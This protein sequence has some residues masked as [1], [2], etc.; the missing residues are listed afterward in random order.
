MR[1]HL[2]RVTAFGAFGR[3]A[4]V[5]F[6]ELA[7]SGLFLLHGETGAGKTTLLD[8]IGFALYGRVPG[9]RNKTKRLR[10]DHASAAD[11]TEVTFET[12]IGRR[13]LRIT[14][15]PQQVRPKVQGTGTTSEPAR[16]LLEEESGGRWHTVS[17]RAKEA[18]DEI[19]DAMGMS[20]DQFFQVVLLPQGQ[21]AQFLHADADERR[22]LLQRLFRTGRFRAVE[23]WLA[24]RRK[25]TRDQVREAEQALTTLAARIAQVAGVPG[26]GEE[27]IAQPAAEPAEEPAEEPAGPASALPGAQPGPGEDGAAGPASPG[28]TTA[29]A[30]ELAVVAESSHAANARTA[31]VARS[32]LDAART[33]EARARELAGR[34]G[35]RAALLARRD[36]LQ[37][38]EPQRTA[39]RRELDA[40]GRAA[41]ITKV[42]DDAERATVHLATACEAESAA[43]AAAAA[44]GLPGTAV[45]ADFRAAERERRQHAGHLGA[46]REEA[47]RAETEDATAAAARQRAVDRAAE[48][49]AAERALAELRSRQ[50]DLIARRDAARL[51]AERLPLVRADADR[52]RTAAADA[53][54]LADDCAGVRDLREQRESARGYANDLR[55]I[56]QRIREE[57]FDGMIAELVARLTDD[58]PCP[59]CGSLDHPEP[60]EIQ[61]RR[62]THHEEEQAYAEAEA[63]KDAVNKLDSE[64]AIVGARVGDL[65]GRLMAA[66]V[67]DPVL[68]EDAALAEALAVAG[69]SATLPSAAVSSATLPGAGVPAAPSAGLL[70][71][72]GFGR[73][74]SADTVARLNDLAATLA[75]AGAAV[76]E[77]E[78][79]RLDTEAGRLSRH[80]SDLTGLG[81]ALM[82]QERRRSTLAEQR[83]GALTEAAQADV[84]AAGHRASL[85]SQLD[86]APD[87]ETALAATGALADALAAAAS[88]AEATVAAAAAAEQAGAEAVRAAAGAR[89]AD[90]AA[91]RSAW[92]APEWRAAQQE[93]IR[94]E[95]TEAA[96]VGTQLAGPDLD[97]PL[98]PPA[99]LAGAQESVRRAAERHDEAVT[100]LGR[101]SD[102]SATL[103]GLVPRFTAELGALQPLRE[104]AEEARR[105]ADLA[106]G[107]GANTL[108]MTLSSFVLAARL[109]EVA[110]AASQRLLT[111]TA[112]RYSLAHTD[113]RR[114]GGRAG[115]G[116]LA[117]DTW[118]GQE[119]DTS[120]LSGGET[121]L[122]SL[123]LALGLADVVTAEAAGVTIEALF[124]D[125]GFGSLDEDTLEEVMNVLDGLREGGRM[126][127]IVSHVSELRQ[128]IPAQVHVR[129]GRA[130]STV[131][132]VPP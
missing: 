102:R 110:E 107:L 123:A 26:P 18:D 116:L 118:T 50:E 67:T 95:E 131:E 22:K 68:R 49:E 51:A 57:R 99:D 104:R 92:Q 70:A 117:C 12:T 103:A 54:Q 53:A 122:A 34:Q 48:I 126:V 109:E 121:F 17:T 89:F 71:A 113:A 30:H 35:R 45:A 39:V 20:A 63:A 91:A 31:Q 2:L 98:E 56:A 105:L 62:V 37:A 128:R 69:T 82:E 24:E 16:I 124:V 33:A 85:R 44:A 61:A 8:A 74:P 40:A 42:L 64:L 52:Q 14:R 83:E 112:G 100:M 19:A 55:E 84:R 4:E 28:L 86:G 21:F 59:V 23:D 76:L 3:T 36:E 43:R 106:A 11:R 72:A 101:A 127:G 77:A 79:V 125:E 25:T 27:P 94:A 111:M 130:G 81:D 66:D 41:E 15:R 96:A 87:L 47:E 120:T 10:S 46:L 90:V 13:H 97:V 93:A 73:M 6:D 80:E 115:L 129:K 78:A 7:G 65:I 119:R 132:L 108:R 58:S 5:S 1:P 29:W 75:V 9:E 32:E 38:G 88:A 114:G 60:S